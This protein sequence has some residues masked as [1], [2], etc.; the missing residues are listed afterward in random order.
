MEQKNKLRLVGHFTHYYTSSVRAED[1]NH[2]MNTNM[3]KTWAS[4]NKD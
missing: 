1:L 2:G 3:S 4:A